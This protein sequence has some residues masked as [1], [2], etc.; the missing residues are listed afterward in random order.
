MNRLLLGNGLLTSEGSFWLR[1]RWLSQPAFNRQRI[2]A[3]G[4]SMVACTERMLAGWRDGETRDLHADM[5]HLALAI[6]AETLFGANVG[7]EAV[8]SPACQGRGDTAVLASCR[9]FKEQ[10][11]GMTPVWGGTDNGAPT[12]SP[13]PSPHFGHGGAGNSVGRGGREGIPGRAG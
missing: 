6:T 9:R 12:L 7:G 1:Q 4:P 13:L 10:S 3:Y 2:A 11:G 5:M 8:T